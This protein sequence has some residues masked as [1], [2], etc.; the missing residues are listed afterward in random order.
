M[1]D[2][3]VE[4]YTAIYLYMRIELAGFSKDTHFRSQSYDF[5]L[6]NIHINL[7]RRSLA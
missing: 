3:R 7:G 5:V 6:Q 2:L 1:M 4:I